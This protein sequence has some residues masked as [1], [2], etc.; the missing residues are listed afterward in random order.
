MVSDPYA[1][2]FIVRLINGFFADAEVDNVV[3]RKKV[4]ELARECKAEWQGMTPEERVTA[5]ED[6]IEELKQQRE[7]KKLSVQ[8]VSIN[9]FHDV[10]ANLKVIEDQ[11]SRNTLP[12]I[13]VNRITQLDSLYARTGTEMLLFA[14]RSNFDHFPRPYTYS[15]SDRVED[16][17]SIS[18]GRDVGD[19]AKSMEA[20]CLS[21]ASGIYSSCLNYSKL[22]V[23][24]RCSKEL[25]TRSC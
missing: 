2:I 1:C 6:A 16:F 25:C 9:A 15:T 17:F 22:M 21:G 11:V 19:Y 3:P 14:V 5:T 10:R 8:N 20:F 12:S 24:H 4:H 23:S 18:F 13:A 7:M